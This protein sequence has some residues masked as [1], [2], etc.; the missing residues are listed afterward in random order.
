M[1]LAEPCPAAYLEL[2]SSR[3]RQKRGM[4]RAIWAMLTKSFLRSKRPSSSHWQAMECQGKTRHNRGPTWR[5]LFQGKLM[6]LKEIGFEQ[7]W[8]LLEPKQGDSNNP[9]GAGKRPG[10]VFGYIGFN[11][12]WRLLCRGNASHLSVKFCF[13]V[14]FGWR[15]W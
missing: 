7:T 5:V 13:P 14:L 12:A 15:G 4:C 2:L 6:R 10:D 11:Q 3:G 8:M 9:F 1:T